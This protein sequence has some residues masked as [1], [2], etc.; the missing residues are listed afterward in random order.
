MGRKVRIG[1]VTGMIEQCEPCLGPKP[2]RWETACL[3]ES[4]VVPHVDTLQHVLP[5][6][7]N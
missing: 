6:L 4:L 2:E 7:L 5:V 1:G 3:F